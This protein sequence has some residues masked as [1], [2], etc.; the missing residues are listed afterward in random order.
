[1]VW[2]VTNAPQAN[3]KELR[4]AT[5]LYGG[6]SL[7]IYMH[8]VTKELHRLVRASQALEQGRPAATPI[9]RVYVD[10]LEQLAR[11]SDG[12]RTRV[13][14]DVVSG[15]SAGG[16]NGVFLAK[17][18]AHD[19]ELDPLRTLW[20]D[21]GDIRR[22]AR[23]PVGWAARLPIWPGPPGGRPGPV[24]RGFRAIAGLLGKVVRPL[25]RFFAA[26]LFW[27]LLPFLWV[28]DRLGVLGSPLKGDR[29]FR[30]A[31]EALQAMESPDTPKAN[32]SLMPAGHRLRLFV[33]TTDIRGYFRTIRIWRPRAVTERRHRHVLEFGYVSTGPDSFD[34]PALAL[35]ARATS[36]FPGAFPPVAVGSVGAD[37]QGN[38]VPWAREDTDALAESLFGI[39]AASGSNVLESWFF[40]GGVLDN[41]PFGLA[42]DAIG[43]Q[44]ASTEVD[45]KL[46]YLEP[47][48]AGVATS[49]AGSEP[50]F[51]YTVKQ[52]LVGIPRAEPILDDLER[53]DERNERVRRVQA[54]VR[55]SFP[56]IEA[57]VVAA[58][59]EAFD[60]A[61]DFHARAQKL[62]GPAYVG[63][64]LLKLQSV[65]DHF[66]A[67]TTRL[68][69][70]PV[71]SNQA[72]FIRAVLREWAAERQLT[73]P[74][75]PGANRPP[76]TCDQPPEPL[77]T[78]D[79]REFLGSFDLG[80]GWRRIRFVIDGVNELYPGVDARE[81][82]PL[83]E[84][85]DTA[86]S[87][88][89]DLRQELERVISGEAFRGSEVETRMRALFP[90]WP[91]DVRRELR[92][93]PENP[94]KFA[95]DHLD[96]L[97]QARTSLHD[98]L[99][100]RGVLGGFRE[101]LRTTVDEVTGTWEA[102]ARRRVLVRFHGFA[103]WDAILYPAR[104]FS[105]LDELDEIE[106]MR[107]SPRNASC[108]DAAG[109][110]AAKLTGAGVAHFGAFFSAS[111]RRSD[112]LWGRLDGAEQL[113]A[114]VLG[115]RDNLG[116]GDG[117]RDTARRWCRRA[118][119]A[120]L[121]EEATLGTPAH[122]REGIEK[123]TASLPASP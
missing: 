58:V 29:V 3:V 92:G 17:A 2:L 121:E 73:E 90:D 74:G 19:L 31:Y 123:A 77:L 112:Y 37:L 110:G 43:R 66:A 55:A 54:A 59:G 9:E 28:A 69:R 81:Q 16:I 70:L 83:R 71:E 97:D 84:D 21:E 113:I 89:Y 27:L 78:D 95:R 82:P 56:S 33:T 5:V 105:D 101:N 118:F 25:A 108:L 48:P 6:V 85:L 64:T 12:I 119:E 100:Q 46:L 4:L 52:A 44:P 116:D 120:I 98:F 8:G 26:I 107:L 34:D 114:L 99:E 53:V 75:G 109:K 14:L 13:V 86:K 96:E 23:G 80:Y 68:L 45:R 1:M 11:D 20:L 72:A 51:V 30:L 41:R 102:E 60:T 38:G 15:T 39:Y 49:T 117:D 63:Y 106:V 67:V 103:L 87:K 47:D 10:L 79:Q 18:L 36:C 65:V 88:L 7:C 22:L 104:A 35:S 40:D 111:G 57:I 122:V 62:L 94:G 115:V 93:F 61:A 50:G 42:I 24:R 32:G 76:P 91:S